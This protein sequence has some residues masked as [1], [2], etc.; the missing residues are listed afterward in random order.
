[1]PPYNKEIFLTREAER[2]VE[3]VSSRSVHASL[4]VLLF[5]MLCLRPLSVRVAWCCWC[6]G[7]CCLAHL[8]SDVEWLV[9]TAPEGNVRTAWVFIC[10]PNA[11]YIY[12]KSGIVFALLEVS[13]TGA[14][15][16]RV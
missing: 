8:E 7:F 15:V 14:S 4:V 11:P 12:V 9:C 5:A 3:K 2:F 10:M 16:G 1:M 13:L 6:P